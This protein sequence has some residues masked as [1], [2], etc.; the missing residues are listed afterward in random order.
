MRIY[1][2]SDVDTAQRLVN[3][4]V[5]VKIPLIQDFNGFLKV[6]KPDLSLPNKI[7]CLLYYRGGEGA[8]VSEI[9][10]WLSHRVSGTRMNATLSRLEHER[11]HIYRKSNLC[12]ITDIGRRYVEENIDLKL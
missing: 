3:S 10:E 1:F 5:K 11:A 2:T 6:L 7:L 8:K 9:N 12:L 4:L